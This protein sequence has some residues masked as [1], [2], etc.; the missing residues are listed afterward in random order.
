MCERFNSHLDTQFAYLS[1]IRVNMASFGP[2]FGEA[3]RPFL[4]LR[5]EEEGLPS[6]TGWQPRGR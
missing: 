2:I 1:G 6:F 4:G 5:A 3:Y